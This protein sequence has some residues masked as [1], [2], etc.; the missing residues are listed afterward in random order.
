MSF[1]RSLQYL[2]EWEGGYGN[3]PH[4]AGG[5][6]NL[7]VI[8]EEYD[9]FRDK[10][11]LPRQSVRHISKAEAQEIYK[12][13]YWDATRCGDLHPAVAN[14]LF[15]AD[16]NSGDRR[17]V[18]WLQEA[19]NTLNKSEA[20]KVD[21]ECGP[22]TIAAANALSPP[23]LIDEML[24][25]RLAFLHVAKNSKTGEALWPIFGRG[26]QKRINGVRKQSH[27]LCGFSVPETPLISPPITSEE[28]M[29][30][31]I[32][33]PDTSKI[34]VDPIENAVKYILG[35]VGVALLGRVGFSIDVAN[36]I[37]GN[38]IP[39]IWTILASVVPLG[40]GWLQ[41]RAVVVS[42]AATA[43]VVNKV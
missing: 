11:G 13:E 38:I 43:Q 8:Q 6:T 29:T 12:M 3:N 20:V 35:V 36:G 40:V 10:K 9:R 22:L 4:D 28:S 21:G 14:C 31:L 7:G 34:Y 41:H 25:L 2:L 37:V 17:G 18:R 15:D 1:E 32:P 24:N 27:D 42:N 5:A 30:D 19:I 16:V 33:P 39:V 23:Q 26:W